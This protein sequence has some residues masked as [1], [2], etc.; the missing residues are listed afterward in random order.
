MIHTVST[1]S[2]NATTHTG[3]NISNHLMQKGDV[4]ECRARRTFTKLT[5]S[6][7]TDNWYMAEIQETCESVFR[8]TKL[9]G[10]RRDG[11]THGESHNVTHVVEAPMPSI[12]GGKLFTWSDV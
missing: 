7:Q 8:Q 1:N 10:G 11:R 4:W 6:Y 5:A 12:G 3:Y 2:I 9:V